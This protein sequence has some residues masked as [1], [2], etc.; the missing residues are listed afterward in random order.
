MPELLALAEQADQIAALPAT[1]AV[2]KQ[3]VAPLTRTSSSPSA[4][5][6]PPSLILECRPTRQANRTCKEI[7]R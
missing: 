5:P 1:Y 7:N 6:G 4:L 2:W 3:T